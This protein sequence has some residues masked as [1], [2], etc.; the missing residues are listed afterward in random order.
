MFIMIMKKSREKVG[1]VIRVKGEKGRG[2]ITGKK[3][4]YHKR[5][6]REREFRTF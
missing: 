4:I 3:Y 1:S 6:K 5:T 2:R